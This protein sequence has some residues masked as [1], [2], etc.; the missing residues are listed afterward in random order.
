M[1]LLILRTLALS[2]VTA[3]IRRMIIREGRMPLTVVE[4]VE[5]DGR[6]GETRVTGG[7]PREGIRSYRLLKL[8]F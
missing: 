2:I 4:V 1:D 6:S 3:Y 7:A 5:M 8:I